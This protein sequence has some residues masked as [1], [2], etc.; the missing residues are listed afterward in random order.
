MGLHVCTVELMDKLD[1]KNDCSSCALLECRGPFPRTQS[2]PLT[3]PHLVLKCIRLCAP[4][5][6]TLPCLFTP[7]YELGALKPLTK[8][9]YLLNKMT[10]ALY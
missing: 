6:Y 2:S 7:E 5:V 4:Q 1:E 9:T 10:P 3:V 8:K